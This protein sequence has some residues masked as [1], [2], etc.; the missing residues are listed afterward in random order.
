MVRSS[1]TVARVTVT[2]CD[3]GSGCS[4][5]APKKRWSERLRG[6]V[7]FSLLPVH[8]RAKR[9]AAAAIS[10]KAKNTYRTAKHASRKGKIQKD[11]EVNTQKGYIS[12][13]QYPVSPEYQ[14]DIDWEIPSPP[15]SPSTEQQRIDNA[16]REYMIKA[17]QALEYYH[18]KHPVDR[19]TPVDV[20]L[21]QFM[22]IIDEAGYYIHM[23]FKAQNLETK[24][25]EIFFAELLLPYDPLID[26]DIVTACH[27]IGPEALGKRDYFSLHPST[28][29]CSGN[30]N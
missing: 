17:S 26:C 23:N 29:I 21:K 28:I 6:R 25:E 3:E 22:N 30:G 10:S 15:I 5:S 9:R 8:T 16:R 11:D 1:K 14:P 27:I 18:E 24:A 7:I 12:D 20:N 13:Q 19:Y 2:T 4:K